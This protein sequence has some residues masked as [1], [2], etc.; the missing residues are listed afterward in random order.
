MSDLA[1][2]RKSQQLT[3]TQFASAFGLRSKGHW[4]RIERGLEACPLRLALRI[5]ELSEGKISATEIVEPEDAQLLT[6]FAG[7]AIDR[8]LATSPPQ[9]RA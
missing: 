3:Q 1:A 9:G 6:G 7:R 8:A 5:E 4:S 2:Y